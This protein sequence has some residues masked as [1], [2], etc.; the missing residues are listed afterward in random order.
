[1]VAQH[2]SYGPF[3]VVFGQPKIVDGGVAAV[4]A[5]AAGGHRQQGAGEPISCNLSF[6]YWRHHPCVALCALAYACGG[7]GLLPLVLFAG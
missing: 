5:F 7:P 1:M 3:V 2:D 4:G 6:S